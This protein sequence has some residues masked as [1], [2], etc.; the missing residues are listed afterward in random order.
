MDDLFHKLNGGQTIGLFAVVLGVVSGTV[1][2][3]VATV[4][5]QWRKVRQVEAESQLKRD[6]IAAGFTAEEIE[7]VVQAT[8]AGSRKR[9]RAESCHG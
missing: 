9:E 5:P 8:A 6:L 3:V 1:I 7:R 2:S 4:A